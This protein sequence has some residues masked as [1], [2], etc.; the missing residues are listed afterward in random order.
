MCKN[1]WEVFEPN[2]SFNFTNLQTGEKLLTT[3]KKRSE[4]KEEKHFLR[5]WIIK[6]KHTNQL[7]NSCLMHF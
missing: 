7:K 1:A 2:K 5:T 4:K 6:P 3:K